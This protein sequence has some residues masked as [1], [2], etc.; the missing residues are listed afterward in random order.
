MNEHRVQ[1][2]HLLV[3]EFLIPDEHLYGTYTHTRI[4][5]NFVDCS[6]PPLYSSSSLTSAQSGEKKLVAEGEKERENES[7]KN[8]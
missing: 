2:Q 6:A 4:H 8:M 1:K 3:L 7:A 5:T